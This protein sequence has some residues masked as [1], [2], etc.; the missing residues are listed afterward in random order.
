MDSLRISADVRNIALFTSVV[1]HSFK[2]EENQGNTLFSLVLSATSNRAVQ[3]LPK[4]GSYCKTGD[5]RFWE[6]SGQVLV[7]ETH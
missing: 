6:D 7:R 3:F 1:L 5:T 4:E 2:P